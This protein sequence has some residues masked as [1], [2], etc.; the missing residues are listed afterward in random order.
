MRS[1]LIGL[2]LTATLA[3]LVVLVSA[4]SPAPAGPAAPA[5]AEPLAD[6][7]RAAIVKGKAYLHVQSDGNKWDR[8]S[9]FGPNL[10]PGG[11]VSLAVLALL[12]SGAENG[13][14]QA[15]ID[16]GLQSLRGIHSDG[17]SWTYVVS[18][19]TLVYAL[20]GDPKD[21]EAIQANVK[22]LLEARLPNGYWSYRYKNGPGGGDA[23]NTQYALLALHEGIR[24]GADVPKADLESIQKFYLAGQKADGSWSYQPGGGSSMTMTT[25]GLCG[26]LIT[27]MDLEEGH[28]DLKDD[29]SDPNCGV[30]KE[31]APVAKA[32]Q[33]IADRFPANPQNVDDAGKYF[34]GST[35]GP[36]PFYGL[37]G[38]ERAGRLSGQRF[39]GGHDWYRVGCQCLV[40]SQHADGSWSGNDRNIDGDPIIATSF[41]MLFLAKGRTPVLMTKLAYG[42]RGDTDWCHKH[43]DLRNVVEFASKDLFKKQPMAWQIFDIRDLEAGAPAAIHDLTE[44]LLESPIVY[45]SGHDGGVTGA[46]VD[47]LKEY[48]ENGGFV[49]AEACCGE[50]NHPKG[51]GPKFRDLM[52]QIYPDADL[53][54]L[55]AS[56]PIYSASGRASDPADFPLYGIERGCK[57]IVVYSPKAISGYWEANDVKS[58]KGAKAFRLADNVIAYA[59]GLEPPRP[60]LDSVKIE[61]APKTAFPRRGYLKVAQLKHGGQWQP[62]PKAMHNLMIEARAAGLD[63]ELDPAEIGPSD[64]S[65]VDYAFLYMHGRGEFSFTPEQLKDLRFALEKKGC[66][67]FADACCGSGAF[68]ASF[69]KFIEAVWADA[70]D[71][72]K[73]EPIPPDDELYSAALNGVAIKTVKCRREKPDGSGVETEFRDVAPALE[74]V[75][76]NGR[77]VVIYSRY[78]IGCALEHHPTPGCLGHDYPSAVALGRAA[79]LYALKR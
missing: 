79:V 25:A 60:K 44:Q 43:N 51:F 66:L 53:K 74:G 47:L 73:L 18:L 65:V 24:A 58:D 45:L 6:R 30:Y 50:A 4:P 39:I 36:V 28:K 19:Q 13:D 57:T 59:T 11:T 68:D 61:E 76:I 37:Y 70:K 67:L 27:G 14:D 64:H 20:N 15:I 12:T 55:D 22:W 16:G 21:K 72:P 77:W 31:E 8:K 35:E 9:P 7:V 41:A 26:L 17:N 63:V 71:K 29:G 46:Q 3:A 33:W 38:I 1:T 78:D 52:K 10:I 54:L 5:N 2:T 69:R 62:A 49:F 42:Q 48:L 23:S 56:H 40:N 34:L 32:L 75:K